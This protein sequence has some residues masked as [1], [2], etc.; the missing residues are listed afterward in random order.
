MLSRQERG[1]GAEHVRLRKRW[2][3]EVEAGLVNCAFCG[4]LISPGIPVGLGPCWTGI[5]PVRRSRAFRLQ[6][7]GL[8]A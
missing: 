6:S 2:E 4:E 8:E 3:R 7:G 5:V 1:Y